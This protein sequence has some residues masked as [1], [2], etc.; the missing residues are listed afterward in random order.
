MD[1]RKGMCNT[2]ELTQEALKENRKM[3]MD[4]S[5]LDMRMEDV[6]MNS[7]VQVGDIEEMWQEMK[8][9]KHN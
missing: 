1:T 8:R 2:F 9:I 7:Q 3:S 5:R 6:E 4:I